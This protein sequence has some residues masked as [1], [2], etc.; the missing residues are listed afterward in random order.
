MS[1]LETYQNQAVHLMPT[2]PLPILLLY[3]FSHPALH[4]SSAFTHICFSCL[5]NVTQNSSHTCALCHFHFSV[6]HYYL[7]FRIL[8]LILSKVVEHIHITKINLS[9][10]NTGPWFSS[11]LYLPSWK[12]QSARGRI[13]SNLPQ[14]KQFSRKQQPS[15]KYINYLQQIQFQIQFPL[16]RR[17]ESPDNNAHIFFIADD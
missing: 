16:S 3:L 1:G 13:R 7:S 2:L 11:L 9:E 12:T 10:S 6:L 14:A 5:C 8:N 4:I 15:G 17:T